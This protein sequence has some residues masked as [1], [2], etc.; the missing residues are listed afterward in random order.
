M[1][2]ITESIHSQSSQGIT[3]PL[4]TE[5]LVVK[6]PQA[7]FTLTNITLDEVRSDE[8]LVQMK[9]SGI[10]HTVQRQAPAFNTVD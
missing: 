10:C 4:H 8:V 9:Y 3:F 7:D 5:A 6:E 1:A 2:T